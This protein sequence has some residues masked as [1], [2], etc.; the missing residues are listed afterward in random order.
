[1]QTLAKH[2]VP[3]SEVHA[4]GELHGDEQVN[5]QAMFYERHHPV[6]G[7][8]R[9]VRSAAQFSKTQAAPLDLRQPLASTERIL[10]EFGMVEAIDDLAK[11]GTINVP[12]VATD[13]S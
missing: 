11:S 13:E 12:L 8:L 6:A 3:V 2:E 9:E 10:A 7:K 1:M 4:L 5:A